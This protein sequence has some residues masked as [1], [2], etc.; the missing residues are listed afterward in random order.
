MTVARI[1]PAEAKKL[2]DAGAVLVDI[3]EANERARASIPGSAHLP[4]SRLGSTA[5][6]ANG[7]DKVVFFCKSGMRTAGNAGALSRAANCKAY[8]MDGG[9][10]S[11]RAAGFPVEPAAD[12]GA[13]ATASA[14]GNGKI[15]AGLLILAGAALGTY[16]T[17]SWYL[18]SAAGAGLL[19]TGVMG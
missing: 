11:W 3:R 14:G 1:T 12:T 17:P 5:L 4:L 10:D 9:I 7:A 2:A 13:S 19:L 8:I 15:I 16:V 18:L 6:D